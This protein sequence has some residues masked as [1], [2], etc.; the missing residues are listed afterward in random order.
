MKRQILLP[1]SRQA[2]LEFRIQDLTSTE[3]SALFG[4]NP[5]FSLYELWHQKKGAQIVELE[6]NARMLWGTRLQDAIAQGIADD[7]GL[8]HLLSPMPEYM[9]LPE[10]RLGASFDFS[11]GMDTGLEI[12]NVDALKFR[13]GWIVDEEGEIEA[14]PHI[15]FQ[16][17]QQLLITGWSVW[18]IG[19][20]VGGNQVHR[21]ERR[22]NQEVHAA[23]LSESAK[24]WA[25]IEQD[26]PPPPEFPRDAQAVI[27]LYGHAEPNKILEAYSSDEI[28]RLADEY[29]MAQKAESAAKSLKDT[30][31]AK[32]LTLIGDH[33]KVLGDGFTI[34]AGV[35]GPARVEAY[36]RRAYRGFRVSR[37]QIK[38]IA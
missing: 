30:A 34:S 17:Q 23:I 2:W 33:E 28:K 25:S 14:P 26:T 7:M 35:V 20:L 37:K 6:E 5:Y 12:K 24:F 38:E 19:A 15:E 32:L 11:L 27:K 3:I 18:Y 10:H 8:S 29:T 9:R 1:K 4:C 31:K 13:E 21:I 22:P 16:V 36:D